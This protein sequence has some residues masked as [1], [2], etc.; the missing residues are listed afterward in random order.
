MKKNNSGFTLIEILIVL[1]IIGVLASIAS[2]GL[3]RNIERSRATEALESL[4]HIK[5]ALDA[6]AMMFNNNFTTCA[7][8]GAIG[9]S[10]PSYNAATNVSAHFA[11]TLTTAASTFQIT[12]TRNT[13]D[14][15]TAGETVSLSRSATGAITRAGTTMFAGIQ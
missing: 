8:F 13:V 7:N 9:M 12:A 10:D 14:N 5:R 4:G 11:Y 2:T 6:C 3:F 15:G 1:I